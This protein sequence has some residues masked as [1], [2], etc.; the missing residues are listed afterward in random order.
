MG[1]ESAKYYTLTS[2]TFKDDCTLVSTV[3][4]NKNNYTKRQILQ[5]DKSVRL[6]KMIA[7]PSIKD[8]T[9]A[10]TTRLV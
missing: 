1:E 8:F 5:A 10:L 2:I 9:S 3:D 4:A 7:L 6:Y